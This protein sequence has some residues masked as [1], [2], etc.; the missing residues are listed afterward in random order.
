MPCLVSI[1]P[2]VCHEEPENILPEKMFVNPIQWDLNEQLFELSQHQPSPPECPAG[3]IYVPE[4]FRTS[5]ISS[6]HSS[7]GTGHPGINKTYST[8]QTRYWWPSMV[9][10]IRTY[11]QGCILCAMNK[12]PRHLPTEKLMPLPVPP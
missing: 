1:P 5:L 6:V 7:V 9:Q 2:K 12:N 11:I 8:L 3:K 4:E 10:D